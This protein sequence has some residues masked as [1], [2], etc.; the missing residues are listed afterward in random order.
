MP[1]LNDEVSNTWKS[2]TYRDHYYPFSFCTVYYLAP[3]PNSPYSLLTPYHLYITISLSY[4]LACRCRDKAIGHYK[5]FAIGFHAECVA[6]KDYESLEK[7]FAKQSAEDR[8]GCI[9]GEN[10]ACDKNHAAECSGVVDYDFF[11]AI[12]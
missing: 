2:L 11:Y 5:Y 1:S 9:N 7:M 3:P 8:S 6:G 12:Q 10:E 4:S